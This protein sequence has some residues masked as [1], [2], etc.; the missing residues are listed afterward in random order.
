MTN[1]HGEEQAAEEIR[2]W[3]ADLRY[4]ARDLR[5]T[6]KEFCDDAVQ[7]RHMRAAQAGSVTYW[8]PML[9]DIQRASAYDLAR[10]MQAIAIRMERM[11]DEEEEVL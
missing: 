1:I 4:H 6:V 9:T 5:G 11:A 8:E 7:A 10:T 2:T 3:A